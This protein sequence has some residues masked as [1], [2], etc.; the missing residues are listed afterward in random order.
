M[1]FP[2]PETA[3]IPASFIA[4]ISAMASPLLPTEAAPIGHTRTLPPAFARSKINRVTDALSFTGLVFGI[5]QTAV[6]PPPAAPRAPVSLVSQDSCP[7]P[8]ISPCTP[9]HP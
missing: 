5:Q 4:A 1:V 3:T 7:P 8:P 2:S 9:L 6:N